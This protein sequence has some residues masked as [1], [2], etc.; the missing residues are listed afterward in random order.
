[1]LE[2]DEV[3]KNNTF[4]DSNTV[5]GVGTTATALITIKN[6]VVYGDRYNLGKIIPLLISVDNDHTKGAIIE[7]YRNTTLG[8]TP[9]YTFE[10]EYNSIASVDK[11]ATTVSGGILI[12]SFT[13]PAGGSSE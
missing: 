1:M 7:V 3:L 13:V 11:A 8:G 12:D 9:N 10:N 6:R 4:A 5:S 2:G